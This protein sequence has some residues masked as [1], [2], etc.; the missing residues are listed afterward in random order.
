MRSRRI[1]IAIAIVVVCFVAL[2]LASDFLVDWTWY[3][4]VGFLGVFW[5]IIGAKI[6]L[7][8]AVFV[9]TATV[10]SVNGMLAS[11]VARARAY[12]MA[13]NSPW[14][15]LGSKEL[16]AVIE[17]IVRRLPWRSLVIVIS[18]V[19]ATLV[20][21]GWSANWNLALNFIYQVPYGR[22]DPLYGH[23]LSF[24]LFSLPALILFKDW[25]LLVLALSALIAALIYWAC[26]EIKLNARRRFVSATAAAHGSVL[27][28][29]SFW[30]K[31]GRSI[32]IGIC[33]SLATMVS[34]WER[35][36]LTFT[37]RCR[38]SWRSLG[39][40]ASPPSLRSQMYE[41]TRPR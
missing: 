30:S 21:L 25:M 23:D 14:E 11:R 10:I 4:S 38:L 33:S 29:Y 26:G 31:P 16:P 39:S 36:T 2:G 35:A 32:S 19:L 6:M 15:S 1:G 20:A 27:W 37:S 40:A 13:A 9:A 17:R 24:Y 22:T 18:A 28:A 5:T 7:F 3:S 41:Y 12:L 34:S 8:V